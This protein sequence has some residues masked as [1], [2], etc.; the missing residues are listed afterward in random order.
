MALQEQQHEPPLSV[1][2]KED[3]V[4]AIINIHFDR[5]DARLELLG[6]IRQ[7]TC[8]IESQQASQAALEEDAAHARMDFELLLQQYLRLLDMTVLLLDEDGGDREEDTASAV[9][10]ETDSC[11]LGSTDGVDGENVRPRLWLRLRHNHHN[12]EKARKVQDEGTSALPP[13][14]AVEPGTE[15]TAV[16]TGSTCETP[17]DAPTPS[18]GL[19]NAAAINTTAA[20]TLTED[21]SFVLGSTSNTSNKTG[22]GSSASANGLAMTPP[23]RRI[24]WKLREDFLYPFYK[25]IHPKHPALLSKSRNY[26]P[27]GFSRDEI[28]WCRESVWGQLPLY[29]PDQPSGRRR[30]KL[31][32]WRGPSP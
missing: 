6:Q 24:E 14:S 19:T 31:R 9:E 5:V 32:F 1:P 7:L 10:P 28:E 20:A 30:D 25:R 27:F 2:P 11:G 15:S 16:A 17:T 3:D 12:H 23:E 13:F 8:Q 18:T 22:K 21:T 29:R 4:Q 26:H